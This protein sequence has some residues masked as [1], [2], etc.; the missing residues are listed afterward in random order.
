MQ[1]FIDYFK[2]SLEIKDVDPK[3]YSPLVLAYIGDS[4]YDLVIKSKVIA[5]GN[6]P[7]NKLHKKTSS[8]VKASAQAKMFRRIE[9]ILTDEELV[10]FKRG[11]NAKSS[12]VPKHAALIDYRVATG[13]EALIGFLYL[14]NRFKRII[15]LIVRGV[16]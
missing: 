11:R 1:E 16:E 3:Q 10:I 8:Y 4:V 13:L 6:A 12:T 5:E 15:E 7:V 9:D 14:K 2:D